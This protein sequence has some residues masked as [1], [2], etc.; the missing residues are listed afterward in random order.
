MIEEGLQL[1]LEIQGI[2]DQFLNLIQDFDHFE[3]NEKQKVVKSPA[4]MSQP[5]GGDG[6]V[7]VSAARTRVRALYDA[8]KARIRARRSSAYADS[9]KDLDTMAPP[10]KMAKVNLED[11]EDKE[12]MYKPPTAPRRTVQYKNTNN[13]HKVAT[14]TINSSQEPLRSMTWSI[15]RFLT[16]IKEDFQDQSSINVNCLPRKLL[17]PKNN[18]VSRHSSTRS[19]DRSNKENYRDV[20]VNY[21]KSSSGSH[22]SVSS[23]QNSKHCSRSSIYRLQPEGGVAPPKPKRM[24]KPAQRTPKTKPQVPG[25]VIGCVG[26]MNVQLSPLDSTLTASPLRYR[27]LSAPPSR[28]PGG[29]VDACSPENLG[30][31]DIVNELKDISQISDISR[32]ENHEQASSANLSGAFHSTFN[33]P[34]HSTLNYPLHSTFSMSDDAVPKCTEDV[35]SK[36][37]C[38]TRTTVSEPVAAVTRRQSC[39]R[40]QAPVLSLPRQTLE[41]SCID[42]QTFVSKMSSTSGKHQNS[43]SP[44][45][46]KTPS[47]KP[48]AVLCQEHGIH[49]TFGGLCLFQT[50]SSAT[51]NS[52]EEIDPDEN[53][54]TPKM[55]MNVTETDCD[56]S[57]LSE[58]IDDQ[59]SIDVDEY[60]ALFNMRSPHN[61]MLK[62][63]TGQAELFEIKDP[64][65]LSESDLN[66][67]MTKKNFSLNATRASVANLHGLTSVIS[68]P[69]E[70]ESELTLHA[71]SPRK[72][73]GL[74]GPNDTLISVDHRPLS[75]SNTEE[76]PESNTGISVPVNSPNITDSGGSSTRQNTDNYMEMVPEETEVTC[77]RV[78][79]PGSHSSQS[80]HSH[81]SH[82]APSSHSHRSSR[83]HQPHRQHSNV[84]NR[85]RRRYSST[86]DTR[87]TKM[88]RS[89]SSRHSQ[90]SRHSKLMTMP[91]D[92]QSV[93]S[94]LP[95]H[96]GDSGC[97]SHGS[98]SR[99]KEFT[100]Q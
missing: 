19:Q 78:S 25:D 40:R 22:N 97:S 52:S 8:R 4:K 45:S 82:R 100:H 73:S 91:H 49:P 69:E 10:S 16:P 83:S 1:K 23:T 85:E 93:H 99:S 98:R 77:D 9:H 15:R 44:S 86:P 80:R 41:D 28:V 89:R 21:S 17:T 79:L 13:S 47:K 43:F 87:S 5:A 30:P 6:G 48:E 76:S 33:Y 55:V 75:E 58:C 31:F 71:S 37:N 74:F 81:H 68:D 12:N 7:K 95:S 57:Y 96:D 32:C 2:K 42:Y 66:F 65:G 59:Q 90:T 64:I 3:Q 20:H 61:R 14:P 29:N 11:E 88:G 18:S 67:D 26:G 92:P 60:A 46:Y 53:G 35:S 51:L 63:Q 56:S 38:D 39:N 34:L 84:N 36:D 94:R 50:P 54:N 70:D 24:T 62:R 27:D 72:C